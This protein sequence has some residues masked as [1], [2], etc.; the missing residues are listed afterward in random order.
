MIDAMETIALSNGV[1]MP[2]IGFGVY[3]IPPNDTERAVSEALAAGYRHIDTAEAYRNEEGVGRAIAG[4]GIPRDELFVTT[5]LWISHAGEQ[6]A[7]EAFDRSLE[8]LGLDA[9]DLYLIHQPFGDYYGSWRALQNLYAD[10]RVRAIGVSNFYPD[11]LVDLSLHSDVTPMVNQIETHPFFQ[12]ASDQEVMDEIGTQIESWGGFAE[13]RNGLFANETLS[14]IGAAHGKSVAQVVLRW[15]VQRK[16]VSIP[17][18][19]QA[20]RMAEN[21]DVFDFALSDADMERIAS[22]DTGESVFF[23]HR[24]VGAVRMMSG[25]S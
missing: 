7:V 10:G 11:R 19:V 25:V 12:R 22:L 9:L 6:Q 20:D 18:S 16:V 13:G 23:D 14:E 1:E 17:K 3:Q 2:L 5:K 24:T 15:L 4:S 8:R 21:I